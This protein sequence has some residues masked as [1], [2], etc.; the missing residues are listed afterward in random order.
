MRIKI[1]HMIFF[2]VALSGGLTKHK[3]IIKILHMLIFFHVA[4]S[5]GLTKH[6]KILKKDH[7]YQQKEH[8][9]ASCTE[10]TLNNEETRD[11]LFFECP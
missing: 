9:S 4:L 7:R 2:H 6:K 11:H 3:K 10:Q 8:V 1:L 5:G